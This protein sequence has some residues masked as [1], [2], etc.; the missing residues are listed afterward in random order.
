MSWFLMVAVGVGCLWAM[1]RTSEKADFVLVRAAGFAFIAAGLIGATGWLG[2]A[3]DTFTSWVLNATNS[4]GAAAF[5]TAVVWIL[6]AGVGLMWVGAML[7]D[8]WFK[9]DPPD[10]LVVGGL[11]IPALLA[12]VPGPLGEFLRTVT[13]WAGE[14]ITTVISNAVA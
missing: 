13:T 6:A 8:R 14:G 5:G 1:T 12:A 10:W 2:N 4:I 7:P 11:V 9:F 3:I